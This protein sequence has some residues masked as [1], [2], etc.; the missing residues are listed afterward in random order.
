[1]GKNKKDLGPTDKIYSLD[2]VDKMTLAQYQAG[3]LDGM[4]KC[5]DAAS[6]SIHK[7]RRSLEDVWAIEYS[8]VITPEK[9]ARVAELTFAINT[10]TTLDDMFQSEYDTRLDKLNRETEHGEDITWAS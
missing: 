3:K 7:L 5:H 10:L 1:V 9:K 8:G 4:Y 2:E 6:D